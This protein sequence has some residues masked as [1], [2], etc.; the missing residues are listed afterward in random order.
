MFQPPTPFQFYFLMSIILFVSVN[1]LGKHSI[2]HGYAN[3]SEIENSYLGFNLFFRVF[4]PTFFIGIVAILLYL[5]DAPSTYLDGL[6]IIPTMFAL[7]IT[8]ALF[9]YKRI[10]L[11]NPILYFLVTALIIIVG[12]GFQKY[13]INQGIEK[14]L[15]SEADLR[16][17]IWLIVAVY[18]YGVLNNL[19]LDN[20]KKSVFY[21]DLRKSLSKKYKKTIP[22]KII[23]NAEFA[24][25]FFSIMIQ[26]ELSR[27]PTIRLIERIVHPLRLSKS[28]GVMQIKSTKKLTDLESVKIASSKLI[29]AYKNLKSEEKKHG[30]IMVYQLAKSYNGPAYAHKVSEI[31]RHLNLNK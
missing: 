21:K 5:I 28:T 15:P 12:F 13:A 27:P 29:S 14:L 25:A 3:F 1:W 7:Y 9:V 10:R 18:I 6:W 11:I 30:S 16:T 31:Y 20:E 26:E 4:T 17:E 24:D 23:N 19:K 22:D 2:L 8:I